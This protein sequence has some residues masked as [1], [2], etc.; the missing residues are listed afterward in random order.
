MKKS[1]VSKILF[2]VS[3]LIPLVLLLPNASAQD[4]RPSLYQPSINPDGTEIAFVS[5]G[6]IWTVESAGGIARVLISHEADEASPLYSPDGSRIAF[7]SNRG[8][9][10]DIYIM[11]FNSGRVSRLTYGDGQEELDSWSPDG[12]WIYFADNRNDPGGH[13][14]IYRI[15]STGGTP[16]QVL[17]DEY[18]PEF[19]AAVAADGETIAIAANARMAQGQW[20]RNGSSHIDESEIWIVS[21]TNPPQ[22]VRLTEPGAKSVQPMWT[23]SGDL[24]YVSN[25]SG[26]ENFW[27]QSVDDNESKMLTDFSD[28][29]VLFPRISPN[30]SLIVFERDFQI[31][32]LNIPDGRPMPVPISLL[33]STQTPESRELNLTNGFSDLALSPDSKK[34]AFIVRGEVFAASVEDGGGATQVTRSV[35]AESEI[36][37]AS[38]SNR[39]AYVSR[40][41][42]VPSIFLYDFVEQSETRVTGGD[43]SDITPRFSP[44]GKLLAYA[45]NGREIRLFNIETEEDAFIADSLLWVSPFSP[46][47]PIAWSPA[48]DWIAW[49]A[50]DD[51][52]FS[53][54][55]IASVDGNNVKP[56]SGLANS[57]INSIAWSPDGE[58]LYFDTQ[59]RTQMGQIAAVD[60]VPKTPI[61][62][63]QQFIDLF[64]EETPS[65]ESDTT[66]AADTM[67][68]VIPEFDGINRRLTLLPVGVNVGAISLSPDGKT[69]VF[70]ARAEGQQNLYAYSVDPE[71]TRPSVARQLTS[72]PGNK[73]QPLF[74]AD[75][76][77]LV[78]LASGRI[79]STQLA[80]GNTKTI[81]VNAELDIDFDALKVESF[82]QGWS[83]MRDHFYDSAFHGADWDQV[84]EV[85]EPQ[86]RGAT[87]RAEYSRL[88]NMMLGELNASHLGH[89]FSSNSTRTTTGELGLQ[90][91]RE[92]YEN[93]GRLRITAVIPLGPAH[94]VG[95]PVVGNYLISV[96]GTLISADTN[97]DAL[98]ENTVGEKVTLEIADN[99]D[100]LNL[101]KV[102]LKPIRIQQQRQ[103]AY[104]DWVERK[105]NYVT[106]ES[107]GRLGYVHMQSMSEG[108]LNKLYVDLDAENHQREGVVIDIRNN[109]GGFVNAYALDVFSRRGYITMEIRGYPEANARSMLG[110][111]ALERDTV[112]VVNQHTLSDGEDFT[113]GY[114]ALGLGQVVGEPTAGW[115]IY[116][117]SA[118]LVDGTN[119][120]MPRSRIRDADGNSMERTPRKVDVEVVRPMG[121]SYTARDSQLDRAIKVLLD[122]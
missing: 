122:K 114:R 112:L 100:G 55:W 68:Q 28:G 74:S 3:L 79:R 111:R 85:F 73:S 2:V 57:R 71:A 116:T 117:S 15:A 45:R 76:S 4:A 87:T 58:T 91:D 27:M 107:G 44:D 22:Y 89:S 51:R 1:A 60:L 36:T 72:T 84:R 59:H 11:D 63:E 64:E 94:E 98:L 108:S 10:N 18:S 7:L 99:V 113:E 83:Y 5:G 24:V 97:L 104:R 25:R 20:W 70:N 9:D 78:Y 50:L 75:G 32:S 14:D 101:Q 95:K 13:S 115:I 110:Q 88:M 65:E 37:W 56:I 23:S 40:R 31:W 38:D 39:I 67:A 103:L 41:D 35:A 49:V 19:H 42:G 33:G 86:I 8:G 21:D 105:R 96:D 90:F 69:L 92:E 12:S 34:I 93:S 29:R 46:A 119:L 66:D 16:M 17:A 30:S 54:I 82:N 80:S 106:E 61:F 62:R 47:N 53:N 26:T 77:E 43:D 109:T 120:R 52:M 102:E 81:N 6:D 48:G 121:E 118:E